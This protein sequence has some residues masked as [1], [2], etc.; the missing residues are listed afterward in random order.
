MKLAEEEYKW[1]LSVYK[2]LAEMHCETP[3]TGEKVAV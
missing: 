3:K 2:Q 1:R